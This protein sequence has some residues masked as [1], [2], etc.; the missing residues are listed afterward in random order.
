[1]LASMTTSISPSA[2]VRT[3]FVQFFVLAAVKNQITNIAE[4][5]F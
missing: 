5:P 1:M 2:A 3:S 4:E